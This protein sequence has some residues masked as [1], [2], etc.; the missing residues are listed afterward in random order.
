MAKQAECLLAAKETL[1][2]V[3]KWFRARA[4]LQAD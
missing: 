3:H 4:R 1:E 2:L